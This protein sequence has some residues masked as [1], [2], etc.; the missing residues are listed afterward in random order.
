VHIGIFPCRVK[1]VTAN[2]VTVQDKKSGVKEEMPY[3]LCV[4][5]TGVAP[6]DLTMQFMAKVPEQGKG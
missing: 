2:K 5:S 4:W 3:G 6:T 1:G